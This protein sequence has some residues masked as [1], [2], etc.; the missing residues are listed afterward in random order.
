LSVTAGDGDRFAV[1]HGDGNGVA[2]LLM[3]S[4]SL[5]VFAEGGSHAYQWR[6]PLETRVEDD[7]GGDAVHAPMPGLVKKLFTRAGEKVTRGDP[8]LVLE[9]MKMEHT[10]TAPRD[11]VIAEVMAAAGDQVSEGTRLVALADAN[12]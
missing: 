7:A 4:N 11:G 1:D 9:A 2:H 6:D 12:A 8:L 10:L 5:V 3:R